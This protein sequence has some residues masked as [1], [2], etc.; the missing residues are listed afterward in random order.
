MPYI[1][2]CNCNE[3]KIDKLDRE[4]H[5]EPLT[6][7]LTNIKDESFVMTVSAPYGGGKTFFIEKWKEVL[8]NNGCKT[9]YYNA[10][11][12]DFAVNP[13]ISFLA[14]FKE[15]NGLNKNSVSA[16]IK[17]GS[18][19]FGSK[20]L[21]S[22]DALGTIAGVITANH[23]VAGATSA[24]VKTAKTVKNVSDK[25]KEENIFHE[26]ILAEQKSKKIKEEFKKKLEKLIPTTKSENYPTDKLIIFIDDLDRCRPDY[27]IKFLEYIKHIFD[28][29]NCMFV[30]A[31]DEEQL[32]SAVEVVYGSK[33]AN[34]FLKRII[35][36]KFQLPEPTVSNLI[37]FYIKELK[38][39]ND[40]SNKKDSIFY[41]SLNDIHYEFNISYGIVNA[42]KTIFVRMLNNL[43]KL[44]KLTARDMEHILQDLNIIFNSVEREECSPL[45]IGITY[46]LKN[47]YKNGDNTV[48]DFLEQFNDSTILNEKSEDKISIPL[49]NGNNTIF[50]FGSSL[51]EILSL[52]RI[53]NFNIAKETLNGSY[54][55]LSETMLKNKKISLRSTIQEQIDA[56]FCEKGLEKLEQ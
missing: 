24:V 42:R 43:T 53:S 50:D 45:Y 29:K 35:D 19:L 30:L 20:L 16:F 12:N 40:D 14:S 6:N 11:E 9:L 8:Q 46:I 39:H 55:S 27:A 54:F 38:W 4:K 23:I 37:D 18:K 7:L 51:R 5:I 3:K 21:N 2:L 10:W 52:F 31:V 25:A 26:L 17:A 47:Y 36:F 34:G 13:L 32:K 15:F 48:N 28:V 1:K 44:L 33:N 49:N 56:I 22:A 41:I